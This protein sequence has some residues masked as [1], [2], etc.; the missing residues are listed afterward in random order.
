MKYGLIYYKN[1]SNIGDDILSYAGKRF[2]P[3]V[4]YC[5]DREEMDLFIPKEDEF[6]AAILNG[7][8]LHHG[9]TFPPSPYIVPLF[10]GTH[11]S[12]S[13]MCAGD[14]SFLNGIAAE[15]L[16]ENGPVGCRDRQ[17]MELLE[18]KGIRNYF[19]GCLT[20]TLQR[21]SDVSDSGTIILTDVP[22][23][24]E[25]YLRTKLPNEN[26]VLKT[27]AVSPE[28]VG[29]SWEE[30]EQIVEAYLKEYQGAKLVITTRLHCALPSIALGTPVILIGNYDEDYYARL[31]DFTEFIPC[32][33]EQEIL[34]GK[35]DPL[36]DE[37]EDSSGKIQ[38][39]RADLIASCE[40]FIRNL[41]DTYGRRTPPDRTVYR[42]NYVERTVNMR[43][44]IRLLTEHCL[45][46]EGAYQDSMEKLNRLVSVSKGLL[47]ENERLEKLCAEHK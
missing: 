41:Q 15:Y 34:E 27:H 22:K 14:Y 24:T 9:Y 18:E 4:D 10:I 8:Y 26:I 44:T 37:P 16:K 39:I 25:A 21:F 7:W 47:L 5:I 19:S 2:L 35:A 42:K 46:V 12:R 17:T 40:A 29:R 45:E 38:K 36:L 31:T 3:R 1:T 43:Q 33:D 32:F 20:L 13:Q 6:A 11:F 23:S 30:R 28:D